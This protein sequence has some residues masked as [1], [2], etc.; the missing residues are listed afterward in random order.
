MGE[1]MPSKKQAPMK[2]SGRSPGRRPVR[3]SPMLRPVLDGCAQAAVS[4]R[5]RVSLWAGRK[6]K[7]SRHLDRARL[8]EAAQPARGRSPA[9]ALASAAARMKALTSA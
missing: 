7:P 2:S 1:E 6:Q 8:R 9:A 3:R 5:N 4:L